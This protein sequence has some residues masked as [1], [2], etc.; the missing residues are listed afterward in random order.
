VAA[1]HEHA[2]EIVEVIPSVPDGWREFDWETGR[3]CAA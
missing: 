3:A 2:F 1:L